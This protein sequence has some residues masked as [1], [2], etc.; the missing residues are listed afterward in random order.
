[1]TQDIIVGCVLPPALQGNVTCSANPPTITPGVTALSSVVTL[2]TT[3]GS[4][5]PANAAVAITGTSAT[6][7][8]LTRSNNVTLSVKDFSVAANTA[9]ITTNVGTNITDTVLVKALNGFVGN[10]PLTCVIVGT[11]TGMACNL[12]NAN[13]VASAAGTSVIA[14]LT[15]TA[16]TTPSGTYTVQVTG[17]TAAGSH[18][19]QFTVNIKDFSLGV[20]PD[21]QSIAHTGGPLNFTATLTA[22][23][24]FNSFS[25][26]TCM[27]PLPAGITCAFGASNTSSLNVLPTGPGAN[28]NV[29]I[30]VAN[31]TA[32]NSYPITIRAVSGLIS[33]TQA[34]TVNVTP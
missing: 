16:A 9:N 24:G 28:A 8:N 26:L 17:T 19:A 15:S 18:M 2:Q 20:S 10:V 27:G 31:G 14:T 21:S 29:R 11:P 5:P 13:P 3:F 34:I 4:T 23:N 6:L 30:S 22:L 32:S 25:T 33:R 12:S 7:N 1:M